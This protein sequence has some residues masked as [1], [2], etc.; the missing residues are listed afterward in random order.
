MPSGSLQH[1]R[2]PCYMACQLEMLWAASSTLKP[3]HLLL[4]LRN[5]VESGGWCC[6]SCSVESSGSRVFSFCPLWHPQLLPFIPCVCRLEAVQWPWQL[7]ASK[8]WTG[9]EQGETDSS[10]SSL[11]CLSPEGKPSRNPVLILSKLPC[12][13]LAESKPHRHPRYREPW[14]MRHVW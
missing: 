7:I 13:S 5:L 9:Q 8:P 3:Q 2:D 10:V 11:T 4:H 14:K 1:C 12:V 6:F